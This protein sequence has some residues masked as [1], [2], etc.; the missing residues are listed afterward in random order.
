MYLS[1]NLLRS[2]NLKGAVIATIRWNRTLGLLSR[3]L[4]EQLEETTFPLTTD[5]PVHRYTLIANDADIS[6]VELIS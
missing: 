4:T 5:T 1:D 3:D 6:Q 2:F